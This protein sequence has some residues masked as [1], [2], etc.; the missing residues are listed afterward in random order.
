MADV[1]R[2]RNLCRWRS[3]VPR[4]LLHHFMQFFV[5]S[6]ARPHCPI[7]APAHHERFR[8]LGQT[9]ECAA[10][11]QRRRRQ[12]CQSSC[13]LCTPALPQRRAAPSFNS[14]PRPR[15]RTPHSDK[16]AVGQDAGLY[17]SR[18]LSPAFR[19]GIVT[20]SYSTR[21]I[22]IHHTKDTHTFFAEQHLTTKAEEHEL[23][24]GTKKR[25]PGAE[26]PPEGEQSLLAT[27]AIHVGY[28]G[29]DARTRYC[30]TG[31]KKIPSRETE[32]EADDGWRKAGERKVGKRS[33]RV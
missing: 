30:D 32:T 1:T 22:G 21:L 8:L 28:G 7:A 25:L 15:R 29:V 24:P 26:G 5:S 4:P 2:V 31:L 27:C 17:P 20:Y 16:K 6:L 14:P 13:P 12:C 11:K 23:E 33:P 9:S 19:S 3:P 10:A 18:V